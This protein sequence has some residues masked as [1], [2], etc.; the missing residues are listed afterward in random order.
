MELIA[1]RKEI[2]TLLLKQNVLVSKEILERLKDDDK[3]E[4]WHTELTNGKHFSELD[5]IKQ[6]DTTAVLENTEEHKEKTSVSVN[7]EQITP[8]NVEVLKDYKKPIL[9]K[10]INDFI[11]YF[12]VRYKQ[13]NK[14]LQNRGGLT[15]LTSLARIQNK[16]D[17]EKVSVIAYIVD[18]QMTKNNNLILTIEDDTGKS[19]AIVMKDKKDI[20]EEAKDLVFDQVVGLTG[21]A[22]KNTIFVD[23]L[24]IP[25]IPISHEF[26]KC[27]ED[28]NIAVISDIHL[29]STLFLKEEFESFIEWLNGKNGTEEQKEQAQKTK[30]VIIAGDLVDGVGIYPTQDTELNILDIYEQYDEIIKYIKQIPK[31][32]KIIIIP[33]NH[34]TGRISEPQLAINKDF[35]KDVLDMPNVTSLSNPCYVRLHKTNSPGFDFLIYHGYSYSY[36]GDVVESIRSSGRNVSDRAGPTMKFLLKQRHLAPAHGSSLYVPDKEEDPLIIDPIPDFFISGHIH[37]AAIENYRG[38]TLITGSCWQAKTNFQEKVG[39]EPEPCKVPLINLKTR[40]VSLLDFSK[41]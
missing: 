6:E 33:G 18:K 10:N 17:N 30:Y 1:K 7:R 28:V 8:P 31:D 21:G 11:S 20:Y 23:Q 25:D 14:I 27:D 13:M 41:K 9:K 5:K 38:T 26:K 22:A 16:T 3:V 19:T 29:G 35:L 37:K 40:D 36:Y 24:M 34:D 4:K 2:V 15:N 32:K 39:H 12:N